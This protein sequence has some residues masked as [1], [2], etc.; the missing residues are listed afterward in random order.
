MICLKDFQEL[1]QQKDLCEKIK[2]NDSSILQ[3]I[4]DYLFKTKDDVDIKEMDIS[5]K[6]LAFLNF[7]RKELITYDVK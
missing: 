3:R 7:F 4:T 5:K 1:I 2:K 6:N